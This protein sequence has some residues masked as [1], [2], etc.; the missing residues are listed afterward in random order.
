MNDL[1]FDPSIFVFESIENTPGGAISSYSFDSGNF[2]F[3]A[4]SAAGE[5]SFI[6]I[7]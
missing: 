2:D 3:A 6:F 4:M 1:L 5:T 7:N